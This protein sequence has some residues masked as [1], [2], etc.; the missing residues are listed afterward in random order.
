MLLADDAWGDNNGLTGDLA[1]RDRSMKPWDWPT[2]VLALVLL[3]V[4]VIVYALQVSTSGGL[5]TFVSLGGGTVF[6]ILGVTFIGRFMKDGS[7]R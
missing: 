6:T 7:K 3:A 2:L 1:D 5:R 4:G